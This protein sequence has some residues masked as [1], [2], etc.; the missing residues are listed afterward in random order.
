MNRIQRF[1]ALIFT[2]LILTVCAHAADL[3]IR[4]FEKQELTPIYW[5]EGADFGDFNQDGHLDVV[6]GADIYLGPDF[7]QRYEFYP[8]VA[9]TR[10][11]P[12]DRSYYANNNFFSYVFDIDGDGWP[13]VLTVGLPNT[14]AYWY[15]NPG[16]TFSGPAPEQPD[17]WE[18]HFVIDR[19]KNEAP[20][21]LDIT[22]DGVPELLMAYGRHYGYA[23]PN[24]VAPTLP[25]IFHP[26]STSEK[27]IHHYTHGLGAGDI[28]GDGRIDVLTGDGWLQQPS[29]LQ[30]DPDWAVHPFAFADR[31][32]DQAMGDLTGGGQMYA[33]DVNGDG[34]N[35]VIT[36]LNAHG[37]GL[38]WFE[39]SRS[40]QKI[41]FKEHII[42]S[43][44]EANTDNPYGVQFSQL[45]AV[46]LVDIDGDGLKDIVTGKTYRA[47]DFNDPGSRQAPVIYYF[48]LARQNG[49]AEFV[50]HLIDDKAGIGRRLVS[51][52][53]NGDGLTDLVVG[54]KNGTFVFTQKVQKVGRKEWEKAQPVRIKNFGRR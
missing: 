7:K 10:R 8:A 14:E 35:D 24:P 18:R 43:K 15:Q 28:D 17:H 52:D 50:P 40:G 1:A 48:Q 26:I 23:A 45:H 16:K 2:Y 46:D 42:L 32:A 13:D 25:W 33:Y 44:E 27:V 30:N 53:L 34:L 9:P 6:S 39:Q 54:N 22:G 20:Q 5:S 3:V 29:S 49:Q 4:D 11:S 37:W 19:V 31:R 36:S 47:H 21:F 41:N 51:G 38:A 12:S